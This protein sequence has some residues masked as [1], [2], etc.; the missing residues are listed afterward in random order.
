MIIPLPP[1]PEILPNSPAYLDKFC[2][3]CHE[4]LDGTIFATFVNG[5]SCAVVQIKSVGVHLYTW[6]HTPA[7]CEIKGTGPSR[8][9]AIKA[10]CQAGLIH[11]RGNES[12]PP[13]PN[14]V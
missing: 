7:G 6:S 1:A 14:A 3:Y 12:Q 10:A 4:E 8:D 2:P 11:N 13:A 9:E 5:Q